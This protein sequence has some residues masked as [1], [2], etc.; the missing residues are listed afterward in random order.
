[1]SAPQSGEDWVAVAVM[2][3]PHGMHGICRV[4]TL[5]RTP[6]DFLDAPVETLRVRR[7]GKLEGELTIEEMELMDSGIVHVRFAGINDR[8]A[9][10]KLTNCDLVI[11]EGERWELPEGEYYADHLAGLEL[12]DATG[13]TIGTVVGADEGAAH[14]YLVLRLDDAKNRGNVL[15]PMVPQFVHKVDVKGGYVQATIPEGLAD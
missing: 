2:L 14:D 8:T 5:T 7:N 15:L 13:R 9:A 4:K 1:M 12:R 11:P 3:R 6:D 10:E